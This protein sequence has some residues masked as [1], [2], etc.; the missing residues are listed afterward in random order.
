MEVISYM[1]EIQ[2]EEL[3]DA[4]CLLTDFEIIHNTR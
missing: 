3:L 1:H 4:G 2:Q